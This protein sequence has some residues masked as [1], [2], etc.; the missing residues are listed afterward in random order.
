MTRLILSLQLLNVV[1]VFPL[2][3]SGVACVLCALQYQSCALH[4]HQREPESL[5]PGHSAHLHCP[6]SCQHWRG[7]T[8]LQLPPHFFHK[9]VCRHTISGLLNTLRQ[10]WMS[11]TDIIHTFIN[12]MTLSETWQA[13]GGMFC[14]LLGAPR[15]KS[16]YPAVLGHI[17]IKRDKAPR[18]LFEWN[19]RA[20]STSLDLMSPCISNSARQVT[21]TPKL[22]TL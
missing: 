3:S 14:S 20:T 8:Q 16:Y 1:L 13:E 7:P 22:L 11:F 5:P 10:A 4:A 2:H 6:F 18:P 17:Y 21:S 19:V 12:G 9:Q 15:F